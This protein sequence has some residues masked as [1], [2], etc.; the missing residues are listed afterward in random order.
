MADASLR[1]D[2][3]IEDRADDLL[4]NEIIWKAVKGENA[5]APPPVRA[6][7]VIPRRR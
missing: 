2:L 7:F 4:F 1:L 5:V 6:A 3:E